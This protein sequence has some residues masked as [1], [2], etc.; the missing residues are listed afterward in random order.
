VLEDCD[1]RFAPESHEEDSNRMWW[2]VVF[3]VVVVS[4]QV[5]RLSLVVTE[6]THS[7]LWK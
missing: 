6:S 4:S 1:N 3:V 5:S 2:A 7:G